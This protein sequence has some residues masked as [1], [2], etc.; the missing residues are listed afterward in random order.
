[1]A[2]VCGWISS[3]PGNASQCA[4]STTSGVCDGADVSHVRCRLVR[5]PGARHRSPGPAA[6]PGADGA[7]PLAWVPAVLAADSIDEVLAPTNN[8][9]V[10][11]TS[12]C[13][14][15]IAN[16]VSR[17]EPSRLWC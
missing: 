9:R 10:V 4:R 11:L 17:I 7:T 8:P 15:W 1:M 16:R 14:C 3:A 2:A 5:I 12:L 6:Q 13:A